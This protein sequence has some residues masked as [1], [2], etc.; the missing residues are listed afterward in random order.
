MPKH[1]WTYVTGVSLR[2]AC[3]CNSAIDLLQFLLMLAVTTT[4]RLATM[5]RPCK[6]YSVPMTH[7]LWDGQQC[8][9]H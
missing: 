6:N 3:P 7:A 5:L 9:D 1:I 8:Q 2:Y 4:V